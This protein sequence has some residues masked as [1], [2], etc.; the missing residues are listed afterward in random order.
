MGIHVLLIVI[1]APEKSPWNFTI[2]PWL[3]LEDVELQ[4]LNYVTSLEWWLGRGMNPK[5]AELFMCFFHV[6]D[7]LFLVRYIKAPWDIILWMWVK[8]DDHWLIGEQLNKWYIYIIYIYI[9]FVC[10]FF[11]L[12]VFQHEGPISQA[13]WHI[14]F[15]RQLLVHQWISFLISALGCVSSFQI[16]VACPW[17]CLLPHPGIHGWA[18]FMSSQ[19]LVVVC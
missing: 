8:S 4:W 18:F 12:F 3:T 7:L 17:V 19:I 10:F 11:Y 1:E 2:N 13:L 6:S 14:D 16:V 15:Y 5:M 9:L